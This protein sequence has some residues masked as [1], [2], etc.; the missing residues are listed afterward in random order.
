V[1]ERERRGEANDMQET[2]REELPTTR[3]MEREER[4]STQERERV[5]KGR[6]LTRVQEIDFERPLT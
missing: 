2:E 1:C 3:E 6:M 5:R 4:P